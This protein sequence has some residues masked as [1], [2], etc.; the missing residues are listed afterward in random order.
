MEN[1]YGYYEA[2]YGEGGKSYT[3]WAAKMALSQNTGVPWIMC[4]QWDAPDPVVRISNMKIGT[5]NE[6]IFFFGPK[7]KKIITLGT[8]IDSSLFYYNNWTCAYD[9]KRV[10]IQHVIK[11]ILFCSNDY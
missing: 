1:E 5:K 7:L 10:M 4:Q 3:Q 8:K 11:M 2:A 6:K 9:P